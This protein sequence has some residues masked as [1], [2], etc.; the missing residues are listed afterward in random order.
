MGVELISNKTSAEISVKIDITKPKILV[1]SAINYYIEQCKGNEDDTFE[2]LYAAI[3]CYLE[4]E[5]IK[6]F[7]TNAHQSRAVGLWLWDYLE[8]HNLHND[9]RRSAKAINAFKNFFYCGDFTPEQNKKFCFNGHYRSERKTKNPQTF[10]TMLK[11]CLRD[12]YTC[13]Q[14]M[15]VLQINS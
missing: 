12:T 9:K 14:E 5:S 8:K 15:E 11:N 10:Y 2:A 6:K 4:E 7:T 3:S 13:I 1:N